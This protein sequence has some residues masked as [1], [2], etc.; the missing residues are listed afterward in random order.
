MRGKR[1][2]ERVTR[3][4]L[5]NLR[6]LGRFVH[7][8]LNRRFVKVMPSLDAGSNNLVPARRRKHPLP[9]PIAIRAQKL[10]AD[11][12]RQLDR[13]KAVVTRSRRPFGSRTKISCRAKIDVLD[14]QLQALQQP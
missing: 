11:R 14:S 5:R 6:A 9:Q 4:A 2:P 13:T 1:M 3:D 10:T 8:A 7:G 12:T